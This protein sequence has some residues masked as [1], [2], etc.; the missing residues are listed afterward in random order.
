[1]RRSPAL[2]P[3]GPLCRPQKM[4]KYVGETIKMKLPPTNPA[5]YV[6]ESNLVD[7][8]RV[9]ISASFRPV[10]RRPLAVAVLSGGVLIVL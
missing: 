1:M 4:A 3:P 10:S 8:E 7:I 9:E 5:V 2:L 6:C